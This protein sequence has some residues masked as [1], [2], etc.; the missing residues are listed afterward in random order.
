MKSPVM[1]AATAFVFVAFAASVLPAI[2]LAPV[3]DFQTQGGSGSPS[4]G[5]SGTSTLNF[6]YINSPRSEYRFGMEFSLLAIP[7]THVIAGV[8]WRGTTTTVTGNS[9]LEFHGYSGD[10]AYSI[11]DTYNSINLLGEVV[12]ITP[13]AEHSIDMD[14][15]YLSTLVGS[16]TYFGIYARERNDSAS[17]FFASR[18]AVTPPRLDVLTIDPL[19][20]NSNHWVPTANP[21]WNVTGHWSLGIPIAS[22]DIFIR[23][24]VPTVV[25]APIGHTTVNALTLGGGGAQVELNIADGPNFVSN[26]I[27]TLAT[28]GILRLGN[29][30]L[31]TEGFNS[32]PG[33]TIDWGTNG[34]LAVEGGWFSTPISDFVVDGT[35]TPILALLGTQVRKQSTATSNRLV[36]GDTGGGYLLIGGES[37]VRLRTLIVASQP[38]SRGD[39]QV[40][41]AGTL[42]QVGGLTE[43]GP[44]GD[45]EMTIEQQ[46]RLEG[47]L[48]YVGSTIQGVYDTNTVDRFTITDAGT[49]AK[50]GGL[51]A[52]AKCIVEIKNGAV[53]EISSVGG[54]G[55]A[56]QPPVIR[57]TG[58]GSR[59]ISSDRVQ[60]GSNSAA[61]GKS[62]IFVE[63][64]GRIDTKLLILGVGAK[65]TGASHSELT[66]T[67]AGSQVTTT[68]RV[69]FGALRDAVTSLDIL[70]GGVFRAGAETF[71][72]VTAGTVATAR[73]HGA[74]S[75]WEQTGELHVGGVRDPNNSSL[76]DLGPGTLDIDAGGAVVATDAVNLML[77][78]KLNLQ[79]GLLQSPIIRNDRGG[80]FNFTGGKLVVEDFYG[81]LLQHGGTFATS[82]SLGLT[83]VH[84]DYTLES[85]ALLEIEIAGFGQPGIAFDRYDISGFADLR[86]TLDVKLLDGYVPVLGD[87]FAIVNGQVGL[88]TEFATTN[89][90]ALPVGLSWQLNPS[91][92]TVSLDVVAA[93][94]AG[95][96]NSN[97]VVDAA[98]YIVWRKNNSTQASYDIWRAHFGEAN[99]TSLP[100][101]YNTDGHVD[102]ADYIVW[103]S[104]PTNHGGTP[105]G[106]NTWRANFG[107]TSGSGSTYS[108][109]LHL[110]VPEPS[111]VVPV[112]LLAFVATSRGIRSLVKA[113][114]SYRR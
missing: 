106:Y 18:T 55:D 3:V 24:S 104:D 14:P 12:G 56:T 10:G 105:A 13:A 63:N 114:Q 100:G 37:D 98:D 47:G 6:R 19:A 1:H 8:T 68:D 77:Q 96:F 28:G 80:Q 26:G 65:T 82:D 11:N 83:T 44:S 88:S 110:T 49:T 36:V 39:V 9:L 113:S 20:S 67:G 91:G 99:V 45:G 30:T 111:A 40:Q 94:L 60:M 92:T 25:I 2:T 64:G 90:P 78:G 43:V 17:G 72:S 48:L 33:G 107:Q 34:V 4:S 112:V 79:S 89:L 51:E 22:D 27:T 102:A 85:G 16:A 42:L 5:Q 38:G 23:P 54:A 69:F 73:V 71:M 50:L 103:R 21:A 59:I 75:R 109:V 108:S 95:D 58:A 86:G 74:G 53:A 15:G 87:S 61:N 46:A 66:I 84:G 35:G 70:D 76:V 57:V 97:G 93:T 32:A 7:S 29:G 52:N 81:N 62:L 41:D 101:D 31:A